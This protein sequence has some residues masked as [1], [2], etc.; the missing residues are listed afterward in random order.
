M[1]DSGNNNSGEQLHTVG[2]KE[3]N[4]FG[5]YDMHGNVW[6]WVEDDRHDNYKGAPKD[7]RAWVDKRRGSDRVLRGGSW[8]DY[9]QIC[10]S[11]NRGNGAPGLRYNFVGFRLA[12]SVNP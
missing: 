8:S 4:A 2:E 5:L 10:R 1:Q 3:P 9:A 11:A 12:R 6:E 7:G